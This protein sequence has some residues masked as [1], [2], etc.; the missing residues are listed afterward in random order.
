MVLGGL[1]H[2][3]AWTFVFWGA[4]HGTGQVVGAYG[5]TRRAKRG[6]PERADTPARAWG[7]RILTFNLVCLGWV[8]FRADS[9][10]TAFSLLGRLFTGWSGSAALVTPMVVGT[11]AFMLALQYAPRS[12]AD[13]IIDRIAGLRPVTMGAILA[14]ALFVITTLG[15]QGVAPFIYFRF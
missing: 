3:A 4:L 12:T 8:F 5:R 7:Q 15:P 14:M 9:L 6:L 1:W 13:R 2:G 11:I 10:S